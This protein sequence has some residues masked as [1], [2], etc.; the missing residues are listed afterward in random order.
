MLKKIQMAPV[1][2]MLTRS[3]QKGKN[4]IPTPLIQPPKNHIF[5]RVH[6][7]TNPG[8]S[9]HPF[10]ENSQTK[11]KMSPVYTQITP[12]SIENSWSICMNRGSGSHQIMPLSGSVPSS[13][14]YTIL[15]PMRAPID[16]FLI[17]FSGFW[18]MVST[19]KKITGLKGYFSKIARL[20]AI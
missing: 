6:N 18:K 7:I 17:L 15:S 19:A 16:I 8:T 5:F 10:P 12:C 9:R 20:I 13:K 11:P 3:N 4:P 2:K 1:V 14:R